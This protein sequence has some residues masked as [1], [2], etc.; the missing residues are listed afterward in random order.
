MNQYKV[1]LHYNMRSPIRFWCRNKTLIWD[2]KERPTCINRL[3]KKKITG[4]L[5]E[6]FINLKTKNNRSSTL[7]ELMT[8]Q[9]GRQWIKEI[10]E[11]R[12]K[13]YETKP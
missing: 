10:N 8:T 12:V 1:S 7:E 5:A 13:E 3:V 9:L 6:A 11:S 2:E 4:R